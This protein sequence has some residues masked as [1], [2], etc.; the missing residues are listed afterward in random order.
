MCLILMT[1]S[2]EKTRLSPTLSSFSRR[3]SWAMSTDEAPLQL[4]A[5]VCSVGR[6]AS[7]EGACMDGAAAAAIRALGV[8]R[9]VC[10]AL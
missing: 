1:V 9:R 10:E 3:A 4:A 7:G 2:Y 6:D 5:M 8:Q